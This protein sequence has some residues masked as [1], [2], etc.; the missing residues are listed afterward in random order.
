MA[1]CIGDLRPFHLVHADFAYPHSCI[2][3]RSPRPCGPWWRTLATYNKH[4][5]VKDKLCN[6]CSPW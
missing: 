4:I 2:G 3:R 1:E 5:K 6:L